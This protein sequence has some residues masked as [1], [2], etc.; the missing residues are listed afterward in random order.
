MDVVPMSKAKGFHGFVIV[1]DKFS[2]TV[3]SANVRSTSGPIA[4][5]AF[6]ACRSSLFVDVDTLIVDRDSTL[7][8]DV[9]SD[10]MRKRGI[11]VVQAFAG[12][13]QANFVERSVQHVK[14]VIRTTLDG[15]PTDAWVAVVP[16]VVRYLNTTYQS[17]KGASPY[18]I[19][20]GWCPKGLLPY[21]ASADV[22]LQGHVFASR[23]ELWDKVSKSMEVANAAH[24]KAY[25]SRHED[26]RFVAGDVVL[27]ANQR[28]QSEDGNF[29]LS[30]PFDPNPWI[31]EAVLS[32]V[33]LYLQ[34][35]E[36]KGVFRDV[37]VSDVRMA[38]L[39][40]DPRKLQDESAGEYVV[41]KIHAYRK[42]HASEDLEFLVQWGGWK[43]KRDYTWEPRAHLLPNAAEILARYEASAEIMK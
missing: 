16:D 40:T 7:T 41:Q 43:N 37:H 19:M 12:H 29:N 13:Q 18:E 23:Q 21:A 31:V 26:R 33:S 30:P 3:S 39:D 6:D 17:S 15:L 25:N 14:Q 4:V 2:G 1:V 28:Q 35:S 9:F 36:K 5:E 8:G 10:A 32:E 34:S 11:E 42:V 20:T 27:V 38:V 24:A 22:A